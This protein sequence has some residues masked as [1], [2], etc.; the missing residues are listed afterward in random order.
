MARVFLITGCSS[1]FGQAYTQE[2]LN[3]GDYVIATARNPS[4]LSFKG[5]DEFNFCPCRLDVTD[6]RSIE[7]AF[8]TG[9]KKFGRVDVVCNNAGYGLNGLFESLAESQIRQQIDVNFF[10][11][12][13]VTRIALATMREKQSPPGGMIQQISSITGQLGAF[14][15]RLYAC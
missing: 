8:V 15:F 3:R 9:L 7:D 1:G 2:V 13:A 11:V 4:F 6:D 14:G 12:L 10:G 5:T